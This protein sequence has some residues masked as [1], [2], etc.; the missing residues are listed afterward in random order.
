M[1]YFKTRFR[2]IGVILCCMELADLKK[3][4]KKR[5]GKKPVLRRLIDE[6]HWAFLV[7]SKIKLDLFLYIRVYMYLFLFFILT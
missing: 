5:K 3:K 2:Q 4:R 6:S 7:T 1:K